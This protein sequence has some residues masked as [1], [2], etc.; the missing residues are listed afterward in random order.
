LDDVRD[1]FLALHQDVG[2]LATDVFKYDVPWRPWTMK[3][4]WRHPRPLRD[5]ERRLDTY[6]T[7]FMELD[8]DLIAHSEPPSTYTPAG[9]AFTAV[10]FQMYFGVRDSVRGLLS[11]TS[12]AIG[13]LRNQAD[14]RLALTFS[15]VAILVALVSA[16]VDVRLLERR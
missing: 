10:K 4:W 11:D 9:V 16:L 7:K 2:N 3:Y 1:Q 6:F 5:L 14:F 13:S 12:G 15:V 8:A